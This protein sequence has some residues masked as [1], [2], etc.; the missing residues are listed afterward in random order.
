MEIEK[1]HLGILIVLC[2]SLGAL[3]QATADYFLFGD[4][5]EGASLHNG[6]IES[7]GVYY[8]IQKYELMNLSEKFELINSSFREVEK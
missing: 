6:L 7:E 4:L 8:R 5:L 3:S 1:L 2:L